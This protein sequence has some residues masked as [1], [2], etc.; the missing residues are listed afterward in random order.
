[1]QRIKVNR[2]ESKPTQKGGTMVAIYDD[3]NTRFSGSLKE[4]QEVRQGDVIEADIEVGGRYNNITV[5]KSI[6]HIE[7]TLVSVQPCSENPTP[8][9]P[10]ATTDA[11]VAFQGTIELIASKVINSEHPLSKAAVRW[12]MAR[13]T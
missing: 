3:K 4:L 6:Q 13:L 8:R 9:H 10:Y 5:V 12:A 1:M 7:S 2:V 11:Q